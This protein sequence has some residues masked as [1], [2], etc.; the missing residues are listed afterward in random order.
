MPDHA[1]PGAHD[2]TD[3]LIGMDVG[4]YHIVRRIGV[5]GMG[6]VYE[7]TN[8]RLKKRYAM[9]VL[10]GDLKSDATYLERFRREAEV[11]SK[12]KNRHIAEVIDFN[13]LPD[14]SPYFIMEYLDG[15]D[16]SN[17]L[18][19]R[20]PLPL[21]EIIPILEGISSALAAAHKINV[22]HRDIKPANI[23]LAKQPD[24]SEVAKL[25]D[26]GAAKKKGSDS[27]LTAF[28][29]VL[30]SAFYVSP[31]QAR[32]QELDGRTDIFSLAI[33][34]YEALTGHNPFEC[35]NPN[36]TIFKIVSD[37][38][39]PLRQFLPNV[40]QAFDEVLSR[41]LAKRREERFISV[42]EFADAAI[43]AID[44]FHKR[45]LGPSLARPGGSDR[46]I[47]VTPAR[48]TAPRSGPLVMPPA[49]PMPVAAPMPQLG[50]QPGPLTQSLPVVAGALIED[51]PPLQALTRSIPLVVDDFFEVTEAKPEAGA[52]GAK[53]T[54]K[55]KALPPPPPPPTALMNAILSLPESRGRQ[56]SEPAAP[57]T[58]EGRALQLK[59]S[60]I[61]ALP[62]S[63]QARAQALDAAEGELVFDRL[64][65]AGAVD[66]RALLKNWVG[67]T[68]LKYL[69]RETLSKSKVPPEALDKIAAADAEALRVLPVAFARAS[70]LL[71]VAIEDASPER[72]EAVRQASRA[73][74]VVGI[75][76]LP[77]TV[78][79]GIRR[80]YFSDALAFA[81][82][83]PGRPRGVV[84]E[85]S[86]VDSTTVNG[87]AT[88]TNTHASTVNTAVGPPA[89]PLVSSRSIPAAPPEGAREPSLGRGAGGDPDTMPALQLSAP[90]RPQTD[91][92]DATALSGLEESSVPDEAIE[93]PLLA[94]NLVTAVQMGEARA[95]QRTH[96]GT[97]G[98]SLLRLNLLKE[99]D[100]LRVFSE[101][102]GTKFV[103]S[104]KVTK[105]V[106]SA[107]LL[108][109]FPA[110]LATQL[111]VIPFSQNP[112]TMET[113][114]IAAVPLAPETTTVVQQ[115]T[116]AGA[117]TIYLATPGAVEAALRR[118]YH[119][120]LHV[121]DS[122]TPNGA[123]PLPRVPA[124]LETPKAPVQAEV[125]TGQGGDTIQPV[126]ALPAERA[127]A[128]QADG[129]HD[130]PAEL[131]AA[132]PERESRK[133]TAAA[134]ALANA[135]TEVPVPAE[136]QPTPLS[137]RKGARTEE[138][139]TLMLQLQ[140]RL[141]LGATPALVCAG[142]EAL[143]D[144]TPA[145]LVAAAW[146]PPTGPQ[147]LIG[148]RAVIND[149]VPDV[150]LR[151]AQQGSGPLLVSEVGKDPRTSHSSLQNLGELKSL[152]LVP[153]GG[154]K[155][156]H[157]WVAL[158]SQA[159]L[160][161][162]EVKVLSALV[163]LIA[164]RIDD[165]QAPPPGATSAARVPDLL[166]RF[167]PTGGALPVG[168]SEGKALRATL[169]FAKLRNVSLLAERLPPREGISAL[170]VI[171]EELASVVAEHKGCLERVQGEG[172][173]ALWSPDLTGP[174]DAKRALAC[175]LALQA[176]AN[177][178]E[179]AGRPLGLRI[180][181]HTGPVVVGL[182]GPQRHGDFASIG[183]AVRLAA[184]L[185]ALAQEGQV[186]ASQTTVDRGGVTSAQPLQIVEGY[187]P[188]E[189]AF[190]LD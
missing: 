88:Q 147:L 56:A 130:T 168:L 13:Y 76:A 176:R 90:I 175:A 151:D 183:V 87:N 141:P 142:L 186:L 150:L 43:N 165:V 74:N 122:V 37:P 107:E 24:G 84:D 39:M 6:S 160:G 159:T 140:R 95:F 83:E 170:N 174:D 131:T 47:E 125:E 73:P 8:T 132:P 185:C 1:Q 144:L 7:A 59:A 115:R 128:E 112:T 5:G 71:T 50:I 27:N 28:G 54:G 49:P 34:T 29:Q 31:E 21:K 109:Q 102:Y 36:D 72:L 136:P 188:A 57:P 70:G 48:G 98:D 118:W 91:P 93:T 120:D 65:E 77:G 99:V 182:V 35:D 127:E 158:D 121:F 108:Q 169:L 25:V 61:L 123:G 68:G 16:L 3:P 152:L 52:K 67:A 105:V 4:V 22:L 60:R 161:A 96:G 82:P 86:A 92:E 38:H 177:A 143:L 138:L 94:S 184:R 78:Y 129:P 26:F 80:F 18:R 116:G 81:R 135:A 9:K 113:H 79:A 164:L 69:T 2:T 172:L 19:V 146:V 117:V 23:F 85:P 11:T 55:S 133:P 12:L 166:T 62:G 20:G 51:D 111:R 64:I 100:F 149:P 163:D 124:A 103:K 157:G 180:G 173:I 162:P 10:L 114:V 134:A 155:G 145:P 30:G 153:L 179:L 14:G 32:G 33:V 44:P 63:V 58:P 119:S 106:F 139:P 104:D 154:R 17:R 75:L 53:I 42:L 187:G 181:L 171:W 41:A 167:V 190:L 156:A 101:L 126:S 110:K 89:A 189:M 178:L 137:R 148:L 15:E 97:L 40:P 45:R 66:E 46:Q